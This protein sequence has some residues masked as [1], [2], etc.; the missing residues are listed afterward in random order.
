M[1]F[2]KEAEMQALEHA[3]HKCQCTSA[4]CRHH[5]G[6]ECNTRLE[7]TNWRAHRITSENNYAVANCQ[8]LCIT[9]SENAVP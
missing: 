6:G 4:S 7:R 1:P 5:T 9:C 8:V 2:T 3:K